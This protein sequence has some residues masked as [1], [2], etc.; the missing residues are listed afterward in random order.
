MDMVCVDTGVRLAVTDINPKGGKTVVFLHGW[1]LAKEIF[2]YQTDVLPRYGVRCV[3]IDLRGFG[4][5]D[6]PWSGYSYNRMAD[7]LHKILTSMNLRC[8][9]LF[10]F[11]M[12]GAI[13]ARYLARHGAGGRVSRLVLCGAACPRFTRAPDFPYGK[14]LEEVD[15]L[16]ASCYQDRP[17]AVADFGKTCFAS[18]PSEEFL[19]WVSSLCLKAAGYGTVK[20]LE[21]LRDE[22]L[23]QDLY[24]I[25]VPT[26]IFHGVHDRVCPFVLSTLMNQSIAD[27]FVVPFE[28]SGHALFYDEKEKCNTCLLEF[29][30]ADTGL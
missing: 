15:E 26:A 27:S 9:T 28:Q 20:A 16:I 13:C 17:K 2:E 30:G 8:V 22:D 3:C 4:D 19:G 7:D 11:S 21:S 18:C 1:P 6:K 24:K 14:T 5:S 12:G 29:I 23:R 10:G 25:T